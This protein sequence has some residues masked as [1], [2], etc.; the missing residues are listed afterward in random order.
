MSP[1]LGAPSPVAAQ[2]KKKNALLKEMEY[3]VQPIKAPLLEVAV[4]A[5]EV[6]GPALGGRD[7]E[8]NLKSVLSCVEKNRPLFEVGAS[9]RDSIKRR[10]YEAIVEEYSS[11]RKYANDAKN[12]ADHAVQHRIQLSDT[13]IHQIIVTARMWTDVEEQVD[14]FKR[15]IWRILAGT[16]FS[17]RAS[18]EETKTEEYLS[19]ISILLEL[20]VEDNPIWV[21]LLS[22]YDFLKNKITATA[23]R[24]RVETEV[25]RRRLAASDKPS[26]N[27]VAQHLRSVARNG[28]SLVEGSMDSPKITE[29]WE[30]V[31]ST[32]NAMLSVQ[33][34]VLGEVIEFWETAQSFIDGKAQRTLPVGFD[35]QSQKH[36]RLSADGIS[37]LQS[38]TRELVNLIRDSVTSFFTDPPPEDLSAL[39]SPLPDT[40]I[41]P[42]TPKSATLQT[43]ISATR[44]KFDPS[45]IPP[46][47]PRTG[48]PWERYAFWPPHSNSVSSSYYL[49]KIMLLVGTAASEMASL[50][51]IKERGSN[52]QLKS[53]LGGVRERCVVAVCAA[54]N[55]DAE[56][57]RTLED[58]IRA[59]ERRE[60]T[61]FP[62]SF[63]AFE[64]LLLS[65]LQKILYVSEAMNRPGSADV[66]VPPSAKMLQMVRSQLVSSMYK[67][68][69][70]MVENAERPLKLGAASIGAD[71]DDLII[72]ARN[73]ASA[74]VHTTTVDISNRV[75]SLPQA[76][77]IR[78]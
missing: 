70:G 71:G 57:T 52:D 22:R 39:Y 24:S 14:G 7:K 13:E 59:A 25:L 76:S 67:G 37:D 42:K 3:G 60:L 34:G 63:G 12:L 65:N 26:I 68:L 74:D 35:R 30:H 21:W 48:E 20:G 73:G 62:Q 15:D 47:S 29:F 53:L 45:D 64:G 66:V 72:P 77:K 16:H 49:S 23:E 19:L 50:R 40:P 54:W 5:E 4:K 10:D 58:W 33:G 17:K 78:S 56:S 9:L 75:S 1:Q 36:H 46:P 38:G 31:F 28:G 6:W 51:V 18:N 27:T 55:N 44:F 8:E 61:A 11:A 43:A 32:M 69:A 2:S 41:T